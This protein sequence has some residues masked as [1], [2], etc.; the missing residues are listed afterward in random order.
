MAE[1][2]ERLLL[3]IEVDTE[4]MRREL[5]KADKNVGTF[6]SSVERRMRKIKK[7]FTNAFKGLGKKLTI[8]A[9]AAAAGL[10]VLVNRVVDT[11]EAIG[12]AADQI[13]IT[14]AAL[15]E[16][17]F[18]A[19]IVGVELAQ[20]DK[21]LATFTKQLGDA[22]AGT[23]TLLT[24]LNKMDASFRDAILSVDTTDQAL[25]LL[26]ERLRNTANIFDRNALSA[27]AF[28][29]GAGLAM[30]LLAPKV[31]TLRQQA[32]DL[33]IVI[34]DD[35]VRQAEVLKDRFTVLGELM[36]TKL[37]SAVLENADAIDELVQGFIEAI[38]A[39]VN[40]TRALAEFLGLVEKPPLGQL[41]QRLAVLRQP[42]FLKG[43]SAALQKEI[44]KEITVLADQITRLRK[45]EAAGIEIRPGKPQFRTAPQVATGGPL[46]LLGQ[47][48]TPRPKPDVTRL[49]TGA[50]GAGVTPRPAPRDD[51]FAD[52]QARQDA[53]TQTLKQIEI[54]FL[55]STGKIEAA[56][57]KAADLRK[58]EL[59]ALR[60][61]GSIASDEELEKALTNIDAITKKTVE[62]LD[63]SAAAADRFGDSLNFA[64]QNA[65]LQGERLDKILLR[66]LKS[67][68][69][70]GVDGKGGLLGGILG[71]L[72]GGIAK[73]FTLP[74]LASGGPLVPGVP[75]IVGERGPELVMSR[76][77]ATVLSNADTQR[78]LG[79]GGGGVSITINA[80]GA[81]AGTVARIAGILEA[82]MIPR[83][84]QG[85]R[86]AVRRDLTRPHFA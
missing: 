64:L 62:G 82:S 72:T 24:F 52:L 56:I 37:A 60:E 27:A 11:T 14:T 42:S 67:A 45:A 20:V 54:E 80:P 86:V 68:A 12:K 31:E 38:P 49:A 8:G 83:A 26:F 44:D 50:L 59:R 17:R 79:G 4:R 85:A 40:A 10:T 28:G 25:A 9:A 48:V 39:I 5:R 2:L 51:F 1:E 74:G 53:A 73:A 65:I 47:T 66:M 16:M 46:E 76:R 19:Q 36:K 30:S 63:K 58:D 78:A 29:R 23:G 21:G 61:I 81:D 70:F 7:A 55:R 22:R 32:R 13:G 15:Q 6:Q 75:T 3:R 84:I 43:R 41:E 77:P 69:L 71:K 57:T 35:L 18:A 33:G 34:R